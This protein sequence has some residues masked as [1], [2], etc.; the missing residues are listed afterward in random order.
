M[1]AVKVPFAQ[2]EVFVLQRDC[3]LFPAVLGGKAVGN[4][5]E[6]K[7]KPVCFCGIARHKTGCALLEIGDFS[8][9]L[10]VNFREYTVNRF[11]ACVFTEIVSVKIQVV[12]LHSEADV[13]VLPVCGIRI[14]Q[15]RRQIGNI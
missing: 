11:F 8:A 6:R 5:A 9:G 4:V 1:F 14:L 10:A 2:C 3:A 12:T 13:S 15:A 7:Q